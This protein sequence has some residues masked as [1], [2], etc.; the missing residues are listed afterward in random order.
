MNNDV[1]TTA[2]ST[3]VVKCE[4][5]GLVPATWRVRAGGLW[6]VT[7]VGC[8]G[9]LIGNPDSTPISSVVVPT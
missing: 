4:S 9:Y 3:V 6:F 7:C 1:P 2:V 8:A 5:C